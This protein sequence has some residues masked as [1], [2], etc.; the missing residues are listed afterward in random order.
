MEERTTRREKRP[1]DRKDGCLDNIRV[2]LVRIL[3]R[4]QHLNRCT[5]LGEEAEMKYLY[6]LYTPMVELEQIVLLEGFRI[7]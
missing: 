6:L 7:L 4:T 3:Y 5:A 1:R 2:L